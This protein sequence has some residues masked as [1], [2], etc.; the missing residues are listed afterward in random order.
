MTALSACD[1]A[2]RRLPWRRPAALAGVLLLLI[3]GAGLYLR[4]RVVNETVIPRP[5][6]PDALKYYAYALNFVQR[7]VYTCDNP[8]EPRNQDFRPDPTCHPGYPLFLTPFVDFPATHAMIRR[9]LRVQALI[10]AITLLWVYGLLRAFLGRGWALGGVALTAVSPHIVNANVYLLTETLFTAGLMLAMVQLMAVRR[11]PGVRAGWFAGLAV[12]VAMLVRPTIL[13]W[14]LV[15]LPVLY[16]MLPARR[17]GRTLAAV[18]AGI[19]LVY[20]PWYAWRASVPLPEDGRNLALYGIQKGA[21]V[22]LMHD[23]RPETFGGPQYADPE[24]SDPASLGEAAAFVAERFGED[25]WG[26][27]RWY[28]A[29]KPMLYLSWGMVVGWG[30]V[31]VYP[32][33]ASPYGGDPW[34][35]ITHATMRWLHMPLMI[36]A[37]IGALLV[38]LPS[39]RRM[40]AGRRAAARLA[41]LLVLY[42]MAVHVA[43]IPQPRY[44]TPIRPV[45]FGLALLGPQYILRA[46]RRQGFCLRRVR[47]RG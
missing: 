41:S 21:Y 26:M 29:G 7:G 38:W 1:P 30:D 8:Y 42:F 43:T 39:S 45:L 23:D 19:V 33:R 31:F 35:R 25:P 5:L 6:G 10:S 13:Y 20:G 46:V 24:W 27:I 47:F 32:P 14:P 18:A 12:G 2:R 3:A 9:V 4:I 28:A 15:L 36:C 11:T 17:R 22:W 44:A 37:L 16:W 40:P 34:F